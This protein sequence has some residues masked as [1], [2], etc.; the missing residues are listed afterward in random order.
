MAKCPRKG[1]ACREEHAPTKPKP[2]RR[3][4]ANSGPANGGKVVTPDGFDSPEETARNFPAGATP[5][6][7]ISRSRI[8]ATIGS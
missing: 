2:S 6:E 5:A 7:S 3:R 1:N 8:P 4:V